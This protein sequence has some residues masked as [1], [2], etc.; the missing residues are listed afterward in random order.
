EVDM[1]GSVYRT[2]T[3]RAVE[4]LI[5]TLPGCYSPS[6]DLWSGTYHLGFGTIA[7]AQA[8][9]GV[10]SN[11]Q[12]PLA[13]QCLTIL[14]EAVDKIMNRQGPTGGWGYD[15]VRDDTSVA[16]VMVKALMDARPYLEND[17]LD[18]WNVGLDRA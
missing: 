13:K 6:A 3:R 4:N 10:S 14:R 8:Y 16:A 9:P 1:P 7:L 5:G 15:E 17:R 18:R 11:S 2:V 12:E